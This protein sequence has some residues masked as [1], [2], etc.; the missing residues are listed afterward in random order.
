MRVG[1]ITYDFYP[2]IGGQGVYVYEIYRRLLDRDLMEIYVF[3]NRKNDL[4]N[5]FYASCPAIFGLG[6][7][8][9]SVY[10]NL[11][12]KEW[13]RQ[14]E[15]DVVH[16]QGGPG[17]VF[18][19]INPGVPVVY[20]AHHTY[21]QQYRYFGRRF[22]KLLMKLEKHGY[23]MAKKIIAVSSTTK[24]SLTDDYD[25]PSEKITL[26]P[27]GVDFHIFRP[28][29][30]VKK[31][32]YSILYVGRLDKRKGLYYLIK[33]MKH[34]TK[35][36]P[37]ARLYIIGSGHLRNNLEQL[38]KNERVNNN[39]VFL[40]NVPLDDLVKWYNK[41]EVFVLPSLFEGFG[42]VVLEAIAC[43]TPVVGT[44]VPGIVDIIEHEKT[45]VLVSPKSELGL[46][47]QLVYLLSSPKIRRKL[48]H[49]SRKR[50]ERKFEW[51]VIVER[52]TELYHDVAYGKL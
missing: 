36:L 41:A 48:T 24:S 33:A 35:E 13:V 29:S 43:G 16:I 50:L 10:I 51:K 6:P 27:N 2:P 40:G 31:V 30:R 7:I 19:L 22:Y 8:L 12:I 42:I 44:N 17:G 46:K 38:I 28:L 21:A 20:T 23:V 3:S 1:I 45:G 9:F 4:K 15:L 14:N 5:S 47:E 18:L 34:I 39:V 25:V 52:L 49:K 32:P 11:R 37:T 26:L